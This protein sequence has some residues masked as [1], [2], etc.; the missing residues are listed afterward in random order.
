MVNQVSVV[1]G[2]IRFRENCSSCGSCKSVL[3]KRAVI[4]IEVHRILYHNSIH[5]YR[6]ND[7]KSVPAADDL[8]SNFLKI[9]HMAGWYTQEGK[10]M[11]IDSVTKLELCM[12]Q[13]KLFWYKK[14]LQQKQL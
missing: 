5:L 13:A 12:K 8:L 9:P 1:A 6:T 2:V 3:L 10:R 4:K 14:Q 11:F 7:D